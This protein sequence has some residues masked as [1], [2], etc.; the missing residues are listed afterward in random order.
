MLQQWHKCPQA[1]PECPGVP[2]GSS[3]VLPLHL[4]LAHHGDG[5]W[6]CLILGKWGCAHSHRHRA[7]GAFGHCL[8][9]GQLWTQA[10]WVSCGWM[11]T[12]LEVCKDQVMINRAEELVTAALASLLSCSLMADAGEMGCQGDAGSAPHSPLSTA[13]CPTLSHWHG[14]SRAVCHHHHQWQDTGITLVLA[15]PI[16]NALGVRTLCPGQSWVPHG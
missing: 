9:P 10:C 7:G 5:F 14:Q 16:S 11:E 6:Q 8:F 1:V 2:K 4:H 3:L 15:S 12:W 13:G